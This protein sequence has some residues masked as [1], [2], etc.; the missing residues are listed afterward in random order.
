MV[1][2]RISMKTILSS[3]L[4]SMTNNLYF[5][6]VNPVT[7]ITAAR[8]SSEANDIVENVTKSVTELESNMNNAPN[9]NIVLQEEINR[10][11]VSSKSG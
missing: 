10:T 9:P 5:L 1:Y 7:Y 4:V 11:N 8:I 6:S 3:K 2:G